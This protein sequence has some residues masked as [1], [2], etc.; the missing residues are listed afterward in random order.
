MNNHTEEELKILRNKYL[1]NPPEGMTT[2]DIKNMTMILMT[3]LV[4]KVFISS[5]LIPF[6]FLCL[7]F[8]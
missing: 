1:Q 2:N 3:I 4:K 7:P 5:K 8:W 6:L